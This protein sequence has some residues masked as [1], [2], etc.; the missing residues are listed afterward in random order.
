MEG[1]ARAGAA[2]VETDAPAMVVGAEGW[3]AGV[4]GIIA[5][6]LVDRFARPAIAIGFRDGE[7]RG[8]AR[9]VAGVEPV[10]RA[11]ALRAHLTRFGGHAGAAGM[12]IAIDS[13]PAFRAAFAAEA[14]RWPPAGRSGG[15]EVDAEVTL[16]DLDRGFTE[17]LARLGPFASPT[18]SRCSRSAA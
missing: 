15:L 11:G 16:G 9:T 7:G 1:G 14:A 3:H 13:S 8:S 17:E 5:A 18:A 2:Q 10:R 12:S 4:V 6:R